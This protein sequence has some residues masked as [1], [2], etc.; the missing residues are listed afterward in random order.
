MT[1]INGSCRNIGNGL[2]LFPKYAGLRDSSEFIFDGPQQGLTP[3]GGLTHLLARTETT[4]KYPGLAE[5]VM[6]T[7][8]PLYSGDVLR[9]GWTDLFSTLPDIDFHIKQWFDDSE[10]MHNDAMTWQLGHLLDTCFKMDAA[11]H[12]NAMERTSLT[13]IRSRWIE[14][15]FADQPS[16]E[17]IL[18]SLTQIEKLDLN[19][20][21]NTSDANFSSSAAAAS[22]SSFTVDRAIVKLG[23][24]KMHFALTPW[25]VAA[26]PEDVPAESAAQIFREYFFETNEKG[27]LVASRHDTAKLL[28]WREFRRSEYEAFKRNKHASH[29]RHIFARVE[30][31]EGKLV[32]F[33]FSFDSS[34]AE[35][36][37]GSSV[38]STD[39][40][41]DAT[42][43]Q[44][45]LAK[46]KKALAA[47]L[48]YPSD[49]DIDV[50]WSIPTLESAAIRND[51]DLVQLLHAD[52]GLDDPARP[53]KFPP[54]YF[55]VV[56]KRLHFSEW[57]FSVKHQL[58]LS[59][60]FALKASFALL[61]SVRGA[62]EHQV[63][64]VSE[65][66]ALEFRYLSKVIKRRDFYEIGSPSM[67]PA[68]Q[69]AALAS[70]NEN[71]I[72]SSLFPALP[73]LQF[74]DVFERDVEIEGHK[75][76]LR[77]RWEQKTVREVSDEEI[78]N[79][80]APL[81]FTNPAE[82]TTE[83][84]VPTET[85][86]GRRV[87]E[88]I[89]EVVG[90]EVV[91]GL[92][93][94]AGSSAAASQ[95]QR[96]QSSL[97]SDAFVPNNVNFYEMARHPWEDTPHSW[98]SNGFTENSQQWF[99]KKYREAVKKVYDPEN[100]DSHEYWPPRSNIRN[101]PST[102]NTGGNPR[103]QQQ[104][105]QQQKKQQQQQQQLEAVEAGELEPEEILLRDRFWGAVDRASTQVESWARE[106][107]AAATAQ[108]FS[109]PVEAAT[110]EE[111]I[112]DDEYYRWFIKPGHNPNPSGII[113]GGGG[114]G[115]GGKAK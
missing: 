105:Q 20:P 1:I 25:D 68:S 81:S 49:R 16:V 67:W 71:Q 48:G 47:K 27:R 45:M 12:A 80:G 90:Y 72:D 8:S 110:P 106:A 26:P 31:S 104:R 35:K 29:P 93:E 56:R 113:R 46:L 57:A 7:G 92:G 53:T 63:K 40:S 97:R 98:R 14:D 79:L 19:D 54:I 108:K 28:K 75:F 33:E 111:K 17:S 89:F 61:K 115:G 103:Q 41:E 39:V 83:L 76:K 88:T 13:P 32:N 4:L 107:R 6:L 36:T 43:H 64:S 2:A 102:K 69:W 101:A 99:E 15:V 5:F 114:R 9:L 24:S 60:P 10:H 34:G 21:N 96:Q 51:L 22:A 37:L 38:G 3:F 74:D 66:L 112:Y 18:D 50:R 100:R 82:R 84:H 95:Q 52:P 87:T 55:T 94:A 42:V 109:Y 62:D 58:L 78:A 73:N 23:K 65:S 44:Q 59:S 30:G 77:P 70:K 86:M 11:Q 91:P 85:N